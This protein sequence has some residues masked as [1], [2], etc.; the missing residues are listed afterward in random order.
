MD[1]ELFAYLFS[2]FENWPYSR[3]GEQEQIAL[4]IFYF[5]RIGSCSPVLIIN[6]NCLLN[7][8]ETSVSIGER[9]P[10]VFGLITF[11]FLFLII[12]FNGLYSCYYI[13]LISEIN[14]LREIPSALIVLRTI[15]SDTGSICVWIIIGRVKPSRVHFS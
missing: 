15:S 8:S 4:C 9:L 7:K 5:E 2:L 6:V 13:C 3:Y 11:Y 14:S 1:M 10:F 12:C